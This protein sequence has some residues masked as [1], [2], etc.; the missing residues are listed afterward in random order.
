M[1]KLFTIFRESIVARML[2]PIGIILTI[3]GV[4]VLVINIKN[5]N[6]IKVE[7]VVTKTELVEE[8]HTDADGNHVDAT[9]KIFVK[10]TVD[11]NEYEE[12]LGELPEMK[13]GKKLTIY[14]NPDDPT[15][16]TQTKSL[17]LPVVLIA[18]GVAALV[19]GI[20]SAVNTVKKL[21]KMDEQEKGWKA[22]E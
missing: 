15:K 14:Y 10:Y 17:I 21:K 13:V 11:G 3:F 19:G 4:V 20:I 5:Q 16:I 18:G 1:N 12:E 22:N 2:I 7:A 8:A 9:Y 6:Y